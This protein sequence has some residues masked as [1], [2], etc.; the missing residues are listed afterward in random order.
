[1]NE[2]TLSKDI[3]IITAEINSYK[4]VAGQAIFEI[5]KRLKHVKENDLAHGE[6]GKWLES[7]DMSQRQAQQFMQVTENF[8]NTKTSSLLGFNKL[9]EV[10][11]LPNEIDRQDFISQ[12]HTIPSSGET[13]TVDEMTVR[14]LREVKKAL[15]E[16]EQELH[17]E[18]NKPVQVET[19]IVEKV[20]DNT[21]YDSITK[22][23][24]QLRQ[25]E[26]SY[27]LLMNEKKAIE[28][29]MRLTEKENNEFQSLKNQIQ[30]LM[31]EKEDIGRQIEAATSISGLVVEIN[32]LIKEKLAPV[33]YSKA[34]QEMSDDEIVVR[35]LSE[36]IH[37]VQS[38]CDEMRIYLPNSNRKIIDME[39]I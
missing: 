35:N 8:G 2:L 9:L 13:K 25:K 37:T 1:M 15:K 28:N 12:P 21:D 20:V 11:Q 27:E 7:I 34:I 17:K 36:I 22:L 29:K 38:W 18:K 31:S 5:G 16:A 3:N 32:H 4:N 14:E 33:K 30:H 6:F 26:K 10:S 23:N 24:N 19:E 39:V